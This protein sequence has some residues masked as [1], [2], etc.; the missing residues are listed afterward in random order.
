MVHNCNG[1][2]FGKYRGLRYHLGSGDSIR[3][4]WTMDAVRVEQIR[5]LLEKNPGLRI[6]ENMGVYLIGRLDQPE[7]PTQVDV[8]G[9]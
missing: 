6:E 9:R 8:L 3:R 5:K 2:R 1:K 4:Q 7:S